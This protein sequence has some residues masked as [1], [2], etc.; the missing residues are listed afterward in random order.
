MAEDVLARKGVAEV[1]KDLGA[2]NVNVA[3]L[4]TEMHG[5]MKSCEKKGVW[6]LRWL[7]IVFG[8]VAAG[9]ILDLVRACRLRRVA[10]RGKH[11]LYRLLETE[12]VL[13][14]GIVVI[15]LGPPDLPH[16]IY[17]VAFIAP[18]NPDARIRRVAAVALAEAKM[19]PPGKHAVMRLSA[20][21]LRASRQLGAGGLTAQVRVFHPSG[22]W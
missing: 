10:T 14:V 17:S 7:V 21:F 13:A 22:H 1:K 8:A 4:A 20:Q 15:V 12:D 16:F 19:Q 18:P 9:I 11:F 6:T 5:H 2:T 3:V